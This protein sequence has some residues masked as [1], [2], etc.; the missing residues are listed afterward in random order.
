MTG[1]VLT[2]HAPEKKEVAHKVCQG[3]K[4][5][6][7]RCWIPPRDMPSGQPWAASLVAAFD[8]ASAPLSEHSNQSDLVMHE[9]F[10]VKDQGK[11]ILPLKLGPMTLKPEVTFWLTRWHWLNLTFMSLETALNKVA[12]ALCHPE[13]TPLL[14]APE[15]HAGAPVERDD[16]SQRPTSVIVLE[17]S[18]HEHA[19]RLQLTLLNR[20]TR[21]T[22]VLD[23]DT[24][25]EVHTQGAKLFAQLLTPTRWRRLKPSTADDLLLCLDDTFVHLSWELLFDGATFLWRRFSIGHSVRTA[26]PMAKR[27]PHQPQHTLKILVV[28][29]P[30]GNLPGGMA[31][32]EDAA[33]CTG[34]RGAPLPG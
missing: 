18:R 33:T 24:W 30:Q 13:V 26:Q 23:A 10:Y 14:P 21:S 5:Q 19:E 32:R 4:A 25:S 20:A 2:N 12:E 27:L 16:L 17:A 8:D 9:L 11:P 29:A 31:G 3:L 15:P 28:A 34:H 22:G 6:D 1:R 7:I